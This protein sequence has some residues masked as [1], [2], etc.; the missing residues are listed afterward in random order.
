MQ[1]KVAR[2]KDVLTRIPGGLFVMTSSY[3]GKRGGVIVKSVMPV[4]EEPLL[5]AVAAWKG[6]GLEPII[7]DSHYF[8]VSMIDPTDRVLVRRFSGHLSEH[9]DQ[10]DSVA[11]ERIVSTSPI[12][13]RSIIAIDCE[14]VRHFD[15][16]ADHEL[17][18]GLVLGAK[19]CSPEH[20]MAAL[21]PAR[22]IVNFK[23][24]SSMRRAAE[25]HA[26]RAMESA[27]DSP[28]DTGNGESQHHTQG[29]TQ[30]RAREASR[31]PRRPKPEKARDRA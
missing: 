25:R 24:T 12:L 28:H 26:A 27:C 21:N 19:V 30:E 13:S 20:P 14:V 7:R 1:D 4:A 11:T 22:Q 10:F 8:G 18:I 9:G 3:E 6:H 23:S 29:G 31:D 5:L 16:E 15:I 17:Y 2:T